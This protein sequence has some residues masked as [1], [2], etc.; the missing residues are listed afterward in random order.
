MQE[1]EA[2]HFPDVSRVLAGDWDSRLTLERADVAL[3]RER[4]PG[5]PGG[6]EK[7]SPVVLEMGRKPR[8]SAG[9]EE[10]VLEKSACSGP[11][12]SVPLDRRLLLRALA[13]GFTEVEAAHNKPLRCKDEKRAYLWMPL[14]GAAP[15]AAQRPARKEE[16][17][18]PTNGQPQPDEKGQQDDALEEAEAL[19]RQLQEAL[20]R[21]ARLVAAL[22]KQRREGRAV[23][24]AADLLRRL[25]RQGG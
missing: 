5:L 20:A 23:K 17:M 2:R 6:G 18:P 14:D 19:R 10:V 7:F 21:T 16:H 1:Q 13:L 4:L 24:N 3:L 11:A 8:V 9:T 12:V 15:V 25:G 22:R